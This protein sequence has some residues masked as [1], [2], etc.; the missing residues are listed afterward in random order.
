MGLR[1]NRVGSVFEAFV[2]NSTVVGDDA[3]FLNLI[4]EIDFEYLALFVPEMLD[5][6]GKVRRG[7]RHRRPKH[8]AVHRVRGR[9]RMGRDQPALG[10]AQN[11]Q[12]VGV[13]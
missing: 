1:L 5:H 3:P 4:F 13:S 11:R 6:V 9:R 12:A 10:P 2:N 8:Q 7:H